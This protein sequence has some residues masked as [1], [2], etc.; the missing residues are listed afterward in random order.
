MIAPL[1][2][3]WQLFSGLQL[4]TNSSI[5]NSRF[6]G[7]EEA[8]DTLLSETPKDD[9]TYVPQIVLKRFT[10]LSGNR[11]AKHRQRQQILHE[12]QRNLEDQVSKPSDPFHIAIQREQ[13]ER[14]RTQSTPDEWYL[15]ETLAAGH[16]YQEL[17]EY[18]GI[19]VSSFKTQV[20]RLRERL[21][22]CSNE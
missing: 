8:L 16:T 18:R 15:L 1:P 5:L 3:F 22:R 9:G 7:T 4:Q 12:K 6:W 21:V 13:M 14:L 17:A 11:A 2:S 20:F 10:N 19:T